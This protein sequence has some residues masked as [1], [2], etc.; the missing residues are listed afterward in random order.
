VLSDIEPSDLPA[1]SDSA[2][3][4]SARPR[5]AVCFAIRVLAT[6]TNE[7]SLAVGQYIVRIESS[8]LHDRSWVVTTPD[9]A[10]AR[11][12]GREES[13]RGYWE[14]CGFSDWTIAIDQVPPGCST[15]CR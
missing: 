1:A 12:W 7:P 10:E 2:T 15:V 3:S 8:N 5:L 6:A 4:V 9:A 14:M 11:R 13:A